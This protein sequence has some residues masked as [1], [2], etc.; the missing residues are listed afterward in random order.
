MTYTYLSLLVITTLL[1]VIG[2]LSWVVAEQ[3]KSIRN[4][5]DLAHRDRVDSRARF[6]ELISNS[7]S[8]YRALVQSY[9]RQEGKVYVTPVTTF[10]GKIN[11]PPST[12]DP[13][14]HAFKIKPPP[15]L[16]VGQPGIN[17][18]RPRDK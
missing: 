8:E 11:A 12:P 9:V 10:D 15:P 4:I 2:L 1:L 3:G 18:A 14:T 6:M 7:L 5:T 13:P 16:V 17:A